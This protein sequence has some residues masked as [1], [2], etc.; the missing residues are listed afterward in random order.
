MCF[1]SILFIIMETL[2]ILFVNI[3]RHQNKQ[4]Y[5]LVSI[6]SVLFPHPIFAMHGMIQY[7]N[8]LGYLFWML[9]KH[10]GADHYPMSYLIFG[11]DA[12]RLNIRCY[13]N[14][15]NRKQDWGDTFIRILV[16]ISRDC[17]EI[18][19]ILQLEVSTHLRSIE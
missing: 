5:I 9:L 3:S 13:L 7:K 15:L 18:H 1:L 8:A 4:I 14:V 12:L 10:E 19:L 16:Y 11:L 17:E 6:R 2:W